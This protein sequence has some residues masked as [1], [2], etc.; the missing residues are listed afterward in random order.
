LYKKHA[1][2]EFCRFAARLPKNALYTLMSIVGTASELA[3]ALNT[4]K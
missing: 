3:Q 4:E 2:R 1:G